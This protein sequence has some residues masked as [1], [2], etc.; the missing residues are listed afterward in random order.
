[1]IAPPALDL[2]SG[3]PVVL[4]HGVGPGPGTFSRVARELATDHRVVVLERAWDPD[5]PPTLAEQAAAVSEAIGALGLVHPTLVGVSGGATLALV[6]AIRHPDRIGGLV[7]HEPLVGPAA[8]DLHRTFTDAAERAA[9]DDRSALDV[10]RTVVGEPTWRALTAAERDRIR[11]GAARARAEIPVFAAFA[12]TVAELATL[13]ARPVLVTVGE[14]SGEE[15][16]A[17]A[18]VLVE[19]AGARV[20][21]LPGAG[22]AAQLD[23]PA[24]FAAVVRGW[25]PSPEPCGA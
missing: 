20:T 7:V 14:R 24:G 17:A 16:S 21:V 11:A 15:R 5:R 1:M 8:P 9:R 4:L 19:L 3:P 13:R 12:P 2:G 25:C 23:A 10:V 6:V 18:A 22:N